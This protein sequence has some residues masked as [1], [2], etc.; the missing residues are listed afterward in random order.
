MR[1]WFRVCRRRVSRF[2]S[3]SDQYL[4]VGHTGDGAFRGADRL[5]RHR[6]DLLAGFIRVADPVAVELI[7][8]LGDSGALFA[9][10]DGAG[11]AAVEQFEEMV[12]G[13][14]VGAEVA[15]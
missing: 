7:G 4:L 14:G 12:L 6:L 13:L 5:A 3:G 1:K 15:D 8:T 2:A 11:V 9:A 10:V